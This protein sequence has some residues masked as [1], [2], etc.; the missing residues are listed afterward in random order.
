MEYYIIKYKED[1]EENWRACVFYPFKK[2][3]LPRTIGYIHQASIDDLPTEKD[4][5]KQLKCL[6]KLQSI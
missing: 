1:G 2:P 4:I 6:G 3:I 5:I